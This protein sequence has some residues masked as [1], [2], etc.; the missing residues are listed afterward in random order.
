MTESHSYLYQDDRQ[1]TG[2]CRIHH[3]HVVVD[4]SLPTAAAV[5]VELLC[6]EVVAV[7]GVVICQV[8]LQ[9]GARGG[10]VTA[11]EGDAIQQVTAVHVTTDTAGKRGGR[12]DRRS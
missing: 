1:H 9:A 12:R 8:V 11:A 6:M 3:V 10:W 2:T 4:Q 5:Q 7:V